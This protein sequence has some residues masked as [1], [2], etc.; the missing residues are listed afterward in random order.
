MPLFGFLLFCGVWF[1]SVIVFTVGWQSKSLIIKGLFGI[2]LAVTAIL[3]VTIVI[4]SVIGFVIHLHP[5]SAFRQVFGQWPSDRITDIRIEDSCFLDSCHTYLAFKTDYSE[6][7]ELVP[8]GMVRLSYEEYNENMPRSNLDSP[9]WWRGVYSQTED[10]RFL[11]SS[12]NFASEVT[13]MTYNAETNTAQYF[14]FGLE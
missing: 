13:T 14:Y 10:I 11:R 12:K 5:P 6:F 1:F 3:T 9:R 7:Q 4:L 2:P 8:E